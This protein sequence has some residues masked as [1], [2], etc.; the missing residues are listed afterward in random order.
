MKTITYSTEKAINQI[1]R[2]EYRTMQE[3]LAIR[4]WDDMFAQCGYYGGTLKELE[5]YLGRR[6]DKSFQILAPA[7]DG[8]HGIEYMTNGN[9]RYVGTHDLSY[10]NIEDFNAWV[11]SL[12]Y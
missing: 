5:S 9:V 12:V 3:E 2:I 6:L 4:I 7:L 10:V 8:I 1:K 11:K